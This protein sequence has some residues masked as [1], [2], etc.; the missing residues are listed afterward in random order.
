[1]R[2]L[3]VLA[4]EAL[5]VLL[6]VFSSRDYTLAV[7]LLAVMMLALPGSTHLV[8][9][10]A[11]AYTLLAIIL[12]GSLTIQVASIT[13]LLLGYLYYFKLYTREDFPR[14]ILVSLL[15][16]TPLYLLNLRSLIAPVVILLATLA[17]SVREGLRLSHSSVKVSTSESIVRLG[18]GLAL[19]TRVECKGRFKYSI[20]LDGRTASSGIR[21][22]SFEETRIIK[23]GILGHHKLRV[24][25]RLSDLRG[26][27]SITHGPYTIDYTVVPGVAEILER[28][29]AVLKRYSTYLKA[30][31]VYRVVLAA[32]SARGISSGAQS[33]GISGGMTT[34]DSAGRI[35]EAVLLVPRR[36]V[37]SIESAV[38]AYRGEYIGLRDYQPGDPPH[39]I[40]WK[41]SM[42]REDVEKLYVKQYSR[43]SE[44]EG[45]GGGGEVTVISDLTSVS[46]ME[47]DLLLQA[48]YSILLSH[49]G[50][51]GD[52]YLYVKTPR[53]GA[54]LFKGKV[55]DV[56]L[57]L[58]TLLVEEDVTPLY[59]YD[60][61]ERVRGIPLGES[62]GFIRGLE[63][64][65]EAYANALINVI[66]RAGVRKKSV[67]HLVHSNA[68]SL[69]YSILSSILAER[70]YIVARV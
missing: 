70:G 1:M 63:E 38:K 9:I 7:S 28:A 2:R 32:S 4:A 13:V 56:I 35:L 8:Y 68:L 47:L 57:G 50:I 48:T 21:D 49:A 23:A 14:K 42:V 33:G 41:R 64:Y 26:L 18:G 55:I 59:S 5:G 34:K 12:E 39:L 53:S 51:R 52:A 60:T 19:N 40:Y 20:I 58:N 54:F 16:F 6:V 69:K 65:Y 25:V 61:W 30:P 3:L 27:A 36:L 22:S 11:Y 31:S 29:E 67:F 24:E 44:E 43:S 62:K 15:A 66:E 10:S 37:E 46:P 45:A 17:A